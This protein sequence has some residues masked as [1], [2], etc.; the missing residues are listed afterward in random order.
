MT[1]RG[2]T[3]RITV[4]IAT[5][6][7]G[8]FKEIVAL[9]HGLD[10]LLLPLGRIEVPPESGESF[11]EN[12]GLKAVAVA[13][14]SGEFALA[15]DS[16]LEVDA[17]GGQPGIHSAR[18]GGHLATDADR[19]RLILERLEG[20]PTEQRAARFRC[21]VAIAEPHG[22]TRFAE[23]ICEGRIAPAPRGTGG[24]GYDPIFEIPSLGKTFAE[25]EP[26]VKNRLSHRAKAMMG[27]RA[28]LKEILTGRP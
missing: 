10:V 6:N 16:G 8:K 25:L 13:R 18:F 26:A 24:F 2:L 9:L 27:A 23:G 5:N 1:K 19:Y 20:V 14:T 28:I 12:A 21:V 7:P 15:D 22:A 3:H 17:L 11:Q 4:V